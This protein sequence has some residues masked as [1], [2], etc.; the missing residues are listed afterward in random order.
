MQCGQI[1][2]KGE[3]VAKA[4]AYGGCCVTSQV[5]LYLTSIRSAE[6]LQLLTLLF[7]SST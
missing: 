5:T 6:G 7:K 2:R 1:G 3:A 4:I